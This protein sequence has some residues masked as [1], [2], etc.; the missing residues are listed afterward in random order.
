MAVKQQAVSVVELLAPLLHGRTDNSG[1]TAL[2]WAGTNSEI[3]R[4]LIPFEAGL[5]DFSRVTALM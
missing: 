5:R 1:W 2:M 4:I 3:I